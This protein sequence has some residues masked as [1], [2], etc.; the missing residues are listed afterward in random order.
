[1]RNKTAAALLAVL[2]LQA[3]APALRE[4]RA[5]YPERPVRML[6]AQSPGGN[7]DIVARALADSLTAKLAQTVVVDNRGGGSGIVGTDTAV[8]AQPDGYTIL[9]VPSSF[10]VNPAVHKLPYDELR[11]LAPITLVSSSPN[12]LV[13]GPALP[14]RTVSELT[15]AAKAKPGQLTFGSSGNLGSTHLAGELF[16]VMT[17]VQ[18]VHVPYKGAASALVDLIAGRISLSFASVPSAM[19]H[20]RAGR[21]RAIAVT[22]EKRFS[23]IPDLPTMAESGLPGFETSAWQGLVAPA[24]TPKPVIERLNRATV[25]VL[26]QPAMRE[27]LAQSGS[28][29]IGSTPDEFWAFVRKQIDKWSKVVKAAGIKAE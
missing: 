16:N 22:S 6:V 7:A 18:M 10:G 21:L 19:G 1:M 2:L 15:Q 12:V 26:A 11:D 27:R 20:I 5:A 3:G 29:P 25:E 24:R 8:R 14:I 4:A 17:G 13:V 28:E 9:L 23:L